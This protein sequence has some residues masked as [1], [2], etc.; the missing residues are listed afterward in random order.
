MITPMIGKTTVIRPFMLTPGID[1][2][3]AL[4]VGLAEKQLAWPLT[5]VTLG[6][7]DEFIDRWMGWFADPADGRLHSPSTMPERPTPRNWRQK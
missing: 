1:A 6:E 5:P 2:A 7:L 3:K 4:W